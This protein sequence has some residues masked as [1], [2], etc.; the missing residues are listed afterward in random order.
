[1]K[2]F[3]TQKE[4]VKANLIKALEYHDGNRTHTAKALGIGIR[5]LQRHLR[6]EGLENYLLKT[7]TES[8]KTV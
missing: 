2:P 6:K 8:E 5:T 1:M 3:V 4:A 7:N